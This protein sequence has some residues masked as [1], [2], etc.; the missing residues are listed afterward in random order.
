[1]TKAPDAEQRYCERRQIAARRHSDQDERRGCEAQTA[2]PGQR[3]GTAQTCGPHCDGPHLRR[4]DRGRGKERAGVFIPGG[5]L[6]A[7]SKEL[8]FGSVWGPLENLSFHCSRSQT[9]TS[10]PGSVPRGLAPL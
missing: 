6:G 3:L 2:L 8:L 9:A 10:S 4:G 7:Q 1:M 5:K